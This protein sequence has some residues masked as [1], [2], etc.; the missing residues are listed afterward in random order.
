MAAVNY[1]CNTGGITTAGGLEA[2]GCQ[3][4]SGTPAHDGFHPGSWLVTAGDQL[5]R[6]ENGVTISGVPAAPASGGTLTASGN[7]V[8]LGFEPQ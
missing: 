6:C 4:Q 3:A 7:I 1:I 2:G 8:Q 5:F